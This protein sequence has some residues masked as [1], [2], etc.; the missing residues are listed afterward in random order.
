MADLNQPSD[1]ARETLRRLAVQRLHPTPDNYRALY[2]EIAG[3]PET[4][5]FPERSLKAIAA[6]LPRGTADQQRVARLIEKAIAERDWNSLK[7]ALIAAPRTTE[8]T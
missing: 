5:Q 3:T 7:G 1:I 4:E 8:K 2:H 6:A